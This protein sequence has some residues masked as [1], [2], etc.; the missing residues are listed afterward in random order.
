MI[1]P[2]YLIGLVFIILLTGQNGFSQDRVNQC[3]TVLGLEPTTFRVDPQFWQYRSGTIERLPIF[4][5]WFLEPTRIP[6]WEKHYREYFLSNPKK[7]HS[8]GTFLTPIIGYGSVRTLIEPSLLE[9]LQQQATLDSAFER[10]INLLNGTNYTEFPS[11]LPPSLKKPLALLLLSIHSF[12]KKRELAL[13]SFSAD[14]KSQI[15]QTLREPFEKT[16]QQDS[17][18]KPEEEEWR[19]FYQQI[20]SLQKVNFFPFYAGIEDLNRT[21]DGIIDSLQLNTIVYKTL[22]WSYPT[23]YGWISINQG[24][25]S[26]IDHPNEHLLLHLDFSGNSFY[27]QGGASFEDSFPV[28]II[29]DF[30][31]DDVYSA[32]A[33]EPA[34]GVGMLGYGL[35]YDHRGDDRY[36]HKGFYSQGAGCGGFGALI[37]AEGN[38]HYELVGGGQGF[39]YFGCGVLADLNGNDEYHC[40]LEAQGCGFPKGVGLLWDQFGNDRYLAN[41]STIVFP[42]SQTKEHNS[43]MAQGAG[44]GFRRDFLDGRSLAGGVGM[45]LDGKGDDQYWGGVFC[46]AVGYWYGIG[47]LDDV[48][49]ND[50]YRGVWYS[51]SATAHFGISYLH[52]GSGDDTYQ[53]V[54]TMGVG[55]A[56]DYSVSVFEDKKGNDR[57]QVSANAVGTSLNSSVCVF[58][59]FDGNDFYAKG[60]SLGACQNQS[61]SG[62]RA[63]MLTA[64]LCLDLNGKDQYE[65]PLYQ[66]KKRLIYPYQGKPIMKGLFW[67]FSKTP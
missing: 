8:I 33:D 31:G 42:S 65:N 29:L 4:D 13:S 37:D 28:S 6:F 63:E 64:A 41:D 67:D 32:S 21:L 5:R 26:V 58:L 45:L 27:P 48:E 9:H 62:L 14:E 34:F 53:S 49:G 61:Q 35:V 50:S 3:L 57:Y 15:L 56:H 25:Q 22:H 40:F 7:V 1:R 36:L 2:F 18:P 59:D 51:Q 54:M 16:I 38:D 66:N 46:Q 30:E 60:A 39:G 19:L 55:A 17:I 43:S 20:S 47:I 11:D 12:L 44:F 52:D 24:I 10:A 23:K